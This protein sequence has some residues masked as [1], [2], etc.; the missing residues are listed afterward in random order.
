LLRHPQAMFL[1]IRV[2]C[3]LG[4]L[5]EVRS[6]AQELKREFTVAFR[7]RQWRASILRNRR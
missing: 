3:F 6:Q 1:Q 5:P 7:S 2:E 4:E